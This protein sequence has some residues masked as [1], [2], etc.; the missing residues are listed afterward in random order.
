MV[1]ILHGLNIF[2]F[3]SQV[4]WLK[5]SF[6]KQVNDNISGPILAI[7]VSLPFSVLDCS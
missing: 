6:K 2:S 4:S 5:K 1:S 3:L 7:A